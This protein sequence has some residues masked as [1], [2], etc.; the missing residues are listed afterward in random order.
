MNL[1][2]LA[3]NDRK[4]QMGLKYDFRFLTPK[5]SAKADDNCHGF[6]VADV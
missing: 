5:Q 4:N 1:K 6:K 2:A 3:E